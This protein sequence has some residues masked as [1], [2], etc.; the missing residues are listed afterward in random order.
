[1][2]VGGQK[3]RNSKSKEK[4]K[5][6]YT[7][8]SEEIKN[9][10]VRYFEFVKGIELSDSLEELS[11]FK[12]EKYF[13]KIYPAKF[14]EYQ[15]Y[16]LF[17]EDLELI[18]NNEL[19]PTGLMISVIA[20]L[21]PY[22]NEYK[23]EI[24]TNGLTKEDEIKSDIEDYEFWGELE[25]KVL[26]KNRN[27]IPNFIK[28]E[29]IEIQD[30]GF[31]SK[32]VAHP[33]AGKAPSVEKLLIYKESDTTNFEKGIEND[34][35]T[36]NN[37]D[38]NLNKFFSLDNEETKLIED[39]IFILIIDDVLGDYRKT[40]LPFYALIKNAIKKKNII[41]RGIKDPT[42]YAEILKIFPADII[43]VDISFEKLKEIRERYFWAEEVD[44][45]IQLFNAISTQLK[46][47]GFSKKLSPIVKIFTS[48]KRPENQGL[49]EI[50]I[51]KDE[52]DILKNI[53][54]K[55]SIKDELTKYKKNGSEYFIIE[56]KEGVPKEV[57]YKLIYL[58]KYL[59]KS[60]KW[61]KIIMPH[62]IG[63]QGQENEKEL[64]ESHKNFLE[65]IV[66]DIEDIEKVS[67]NI[68]KIKIYQGI[69][70]EIPN[71]EPIFPDER[72]NKE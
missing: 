37:A 59:N 10:L 55:F 32:I 12:K 34:D 60:G 71:D 49:K 24:Y 44:V 14:N 36:S 67:G 62:P 20:D 7:S 15:L 1:M 25:V 6:F 38:N 16:F 26:K 72:R 58:K 3:S 50:W 28:I 40:F 23:Y 65:T 51:Q 18:K 2:S 22:H 17:D 13:E 39:S 27:Q 41:M 19:S 29:E 64:I 52:I 68:E 30:K 61:L 56:H 57:F 63:E 54:E 47:G 69:E 31:I 70:K 45:G 11:N 33:H 46:T 42:E 43:L 48:F 8:E 5:I 35:N 66:K 4:I 53:L 21:L 9:S